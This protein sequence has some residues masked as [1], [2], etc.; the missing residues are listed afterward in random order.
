MTP[1][2]ILAAARSNPLSAIAPTREEWLNG[3]EGPLRYAGEHGPIAAWRIGGGDDHHHV[4]FIRGLS[5]DAVTC[6]PERLRFDLRR[7]EV[8]D[9]L[10]RCGVLPAPLRDHVAATLASTYV[11]SGEVRACK[12]WTEDDPGLWWRHAAVRGVYATL[13]CGPTGWAG[14]ALDHSPGRLAHGPETGAAGR[15]ACDLDALSRGCVLEEADGWYIPLPHGAVG[16][17]PREAA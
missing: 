11:D 16:W 13:H 7:R 10:V 12:P 2:D 5:V 14:L 1:A 8:R 4:V 17:L 9:R 3:Y 6:G 15:A